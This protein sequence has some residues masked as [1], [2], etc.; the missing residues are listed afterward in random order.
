MNALVVG[1]AGFV[2]SH[3]V[4]RLLAEGH[5]VDVVDDLSTGSLLNL[6]GAR[7]AGGDLS[8]NTLDARTPEFDSL[9]ALRRPELMYLL[10]VAP[11]ATVAA[12]V[13][14]QSV[15]LTVSALEAARRHEVGKVVVAVPAT[16]LYGHPGARDLPVKES[17]L[18]PRGVR[19]V[20]ARAVVDLLEVYR[21]RFAV[22]FTAL[23]MS[24]VYGPRQRAEGGVVA[25]FAACVASGRTASIHGDGRQ[26]RDFV[27]VDDAVDALVRAGHRG[28]GLVVNIGTGVQT[29]IRDLWA[30][31]SGSRPWSTSPARPDDLAR[32][33]VS[34]IRARI[35][36]SWSPWTALADGLRELS[37]G[38]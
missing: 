13:A 34:P 29:S 31:I 37:S 30:S 4:E 32:F 1:G 36:L 25:A 8:I 17:A 38:G 19:G 3:L 9:V 16:A 28:S 23:A 26:T 6:A 33:A 20:M 24:S 21:E 10:A 2:G 14:A 15:V 5:R 18:V 7:A 11:P 12:D 35:H 27:Y 22:E